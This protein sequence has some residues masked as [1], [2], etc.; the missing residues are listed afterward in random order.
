MLNP[1]RSWALVVLLTAGC[2][3]TK[4]VNLARSTGAPPHTTEILSRYCAL[5]VVNDSGDERTQNC[6]AGDGS[7][8][9]YITFK[10]HHALQTFTSP[11]V[12]QGLGTVF[13]AGLEAVVTE[14]SSLKNELLKNGFRI[15]D[16][17]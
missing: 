16:H 2:A 4:A 3:G 5:Q 6:R 15:I 17:N 11:V 7:Y 12:L 8:I 1:R 13:T 9:T 10:D 14:N